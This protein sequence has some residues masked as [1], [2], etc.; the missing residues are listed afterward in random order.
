M[1]LLIVEDET[2]LADSL[3]L[4]LQEKG[5]ETDV[6]YD[7]ATGLSYAEL[8]IYDLVILDVM[9]PGL[10]GFEVARRLRAGHSGVPILMLTAKAELEDRIDGLNAGADYYL[11]K[12]FDTGELLACS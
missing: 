7:G 8:G 4:L 1:K 9:M 5:Y 3:Q 10:N 2:L 11:P 12:P 6:T